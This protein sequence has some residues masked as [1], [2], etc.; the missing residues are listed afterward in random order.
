MSLNKPMPKGIDPSTR[1]YPKA[2]PK[3]DDGANKFLR[4]FLK[5]VKK[6]EK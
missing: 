4:D 1:V 3:V 6:E 2:P 5:I